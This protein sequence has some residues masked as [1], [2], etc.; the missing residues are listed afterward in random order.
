MDR[1][2]G[3]VHRIGGEDRCNISNSLPDVGSGFVVC[4]SNTIVTA[5]HCVEGM[6]TITVVAGD[7]RKINVDTHKWRYHPGGADVA[8]AI[9]GSSIGQPFRLREPKVL[10]QVLTL[11]YP[12]IPSFEPPLVAELAEVAAQVKPLV[13]S[14]GTVTGTAVCYLDLQ[15][16]WLITAKVKGGSSGGPVIGDDGFVVGLVSALAKKR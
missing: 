11:G 12:S 13:A 8:V 6:S 16:Y 10:D 4:N 14:V 9:V 15:S 5:R 1:H 2:Q 7:G 3:V